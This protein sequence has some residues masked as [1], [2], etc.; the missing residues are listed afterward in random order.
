VFEHDDPY[1]QFLLARKNKQIYLQPWNGNS[2]DV[3][4]WK[5]TVELLSDLGIQTTVNPKR[6]DVILV[7]GGNQTMW[8]ANVEV[9]EDAWVRFPQTEFALGPGTFQFGKVD[10]VSLINRSP[11][12]VSA[13][14]ARDPESFKNLQKAGLS[15]KIQLGLSHDPALYLRNSAWLRA[16]KEAATDEYVLVTFRLDYEATSPR[17]A[18]LEALRPLLPRKLFSFLNYNVRARDRH[19]KIAFVTK[20]A[21]GQWPLKVCDAAMYVFE[22]FV[23][24]IRR[25]KEVHTDRL[26]CLLLAAMLD[27]P[28]FAYPTAYGK[29]E[30]VYEHSLKPWAHVTFVPLNS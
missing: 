18:R 21:T 11:A 9:W 26:H 4:I 30:A 17:A 12:R 3:L 27:K 10:W 2:G 29:L 28:T 1:V 15:E 24:I 19:R 5:G 8:K 13:L 25:A 14:F 20:R 23:E 6:A 7:P 22:N 16:H